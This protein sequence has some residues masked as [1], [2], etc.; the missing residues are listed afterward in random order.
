M[1]IRTATTQINIVIVDDFRVVSERLRKMLVVIPNVNIVG[2]ATSIGGAITQV[3]ALRPDVVIMDIQLGGSEPKTG[4]ALINVLKRTY[5]NLTIVVFTNFADTRYHHLC[6]M[7]GADY[8]FDKACG[9]DAIP[10]ALEEVSRG[11]KILF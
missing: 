6:M 5:P 9:A 10:E 4:I 7:N 8:F 3:E 2:E 11:K 1:S